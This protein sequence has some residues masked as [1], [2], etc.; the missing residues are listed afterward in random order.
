MSDDPILAALARLEAGQVAVM[1]RLDRL[2]N[3]ITAIRDDIGVNFARASRAIEV[4]DHTRAELRT[5]G[6]E[7]SGMQRQI[8]RLQ[9]DVR[10]LRGE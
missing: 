8:Q 7:V 4:N 9:S 6:S 10:E 3:A 5:L 1:E 2:Q